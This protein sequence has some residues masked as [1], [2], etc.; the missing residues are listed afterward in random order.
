VFASVFPNPSTVPY[1]NIAVVYKNINIKL[2]KIETKSI[3]SIRRS[4]YNKCSPDV[5]QREKKDTDDRTRKK[6]RV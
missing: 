6:V 5:R 1:S 3:N 2:T 4:V